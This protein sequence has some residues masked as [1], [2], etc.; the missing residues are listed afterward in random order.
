MKNMKQ[1]LIFLAILVVFSIIF[2]GISSGISIKYEI[3]ENNDMNSIN[4]LSSISSSFG[5]FWAILV[6]GSDDFNN[7]FE[8]DICDMYHL[9]TNELGYD[10]DH[11]YYVAPQNWNQTSHYYSITRGNVQQAIIDVSNRISSDDSLFFFYTA[12]GAVDYL[13]G[14]GDTII[15]PADDVYAP[16]LDSW[17][18]TISIEQ[19]I[20][21]LQ[22]CKCGS[23]IDDLTQSKRIILTATDSINLSWADMRGY[24]DPYWDP[25]APDD[26]GVRNKQ[27]RNW[28]GSEFSS[29]FR[30]AFRDID[31]DGYREADD[32]SYINTPGYTPDDSAPNGNKDKKVS[33][34]ESFNFAKFEDCLSTYWTTYINQ[35]GWQGEYPQIDY[36]SIDPS[37]TY[38]YNDHPETPSK[39]SGATSGKK[40]QE[41]TYTSSTTDIDGDDIY[42]WFDW[43]DG[44][45]S[46]WIGPFSSGAMAS[47]KH[48]WTSDGDYDVKVKAR[49]YPYEAESEWSD[50]LSISIPRSRSNFINLFHR[51]L[52]RFLIFEKL[53]SLLL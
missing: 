15:E 23:F 32:D 6:C 11:I 44:S 19:M 30:M 53:L 33:V 22:G 35:E 39:P 26:D 4:S 24:Q 45:N 29:G 12:H 8:T 10:D 21:M 13:D 51:Y 34:L 14:D 28:D 5:N 48:T 20:I 1:I 36:T 17:L 2:C 18:D 40:G 37:T 42:Y 46:G 31:T 43:G 3:T 47:A 25:N 52:D 41:Y 16:T 49:D 9:L 7:G 50:S 38:I 27:N